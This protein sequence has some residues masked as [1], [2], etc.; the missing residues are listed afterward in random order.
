M[1]LIVFYKPLLLFPSTTVVFILSV[2][3]FLFLFENLKKKAFVFV[4]KNINNYRSNALIQRPPTL[5]SFCSC[6]AISN[7]VV[8]LLLAGWLACWLPVPLPFP[9]LLQRLQLSTVL[10]VLTTVQLIDDDLLLLQYL[11]DSIRSSALSCS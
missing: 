2:F 1:H 9:L 5:Q 10:T 11:L 6:C 7:V 4:F 8:N 3:L